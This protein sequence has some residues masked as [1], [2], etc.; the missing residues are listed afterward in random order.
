M[1]L[2]KGELTI[3]SVSERPILIED[4]DLERK[5]SE[6]KKW[7]HANFE[8]EG[9]G[10][11]EV[12]FE[13]FE[14]AEDL[15]DE[16]NFELKQLSH[17]L[18]DVWGH[19]LSEEEFLLL[20]AFLCEQLDDQILWWPASDRLVVEEVLEEDES[21]FDLLERLPEISYRLSKIERALHGRI[22]HNRPPRTFQSL[23]P[24]IEE[25]Q[26]IV[27]DLLVL[28]PEEASAET[29]KLKRLGVLC[30]DI[31][32]S[33]LKY[34]ASKGDVFVDEFVKSAAPLAGKAAAAGL[35]YYLLGDGVMKFGEALLKLIQ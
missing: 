30:K 35:A 11:S 5:A 23:N 13:E 16:L 28:A 32:S 12:I 14:N 33:F 21:L 1:D 34:V 29:S 15:S 26:E 10:F 3:E 18:D 9:E 25:A 20:Y 31:G 17:L 24:E 19:R 6:F 2:P 22:G 8:T 27:S 7:L 4:W